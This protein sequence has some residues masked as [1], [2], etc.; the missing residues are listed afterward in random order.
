VDADAVIIAIG[1]APDISFLSK[2]SQIE[3]SLWGSLEVDENTLATNIPGIFSGGDFI[4]GP[5]TVIQAIAS[6]RRAALAIHK[7]LQ[8][9]KSRVEIVDEKSELQSTA[10]LALDEEVT[11]DQ[12]R[13]ETE[14]EDVG[15]RIRDFREVEKGFTKDQAHR[16]AKRCLRCDL[17]KEMI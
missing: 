17:E 3:R 7:H 9:D 5:S 6:G 11:E 16:E 12:P 10:G 13:I 8:G 4:S 15:E 1:Q 2:D 14:Y